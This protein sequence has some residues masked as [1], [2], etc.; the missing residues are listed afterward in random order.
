MFFGCSLF[1][2]SCPGVKRMHIKLWELCLEGKIASEPLCIRFGKWLRS[3]L[4]NMLDVYDFT[5]EFTVTF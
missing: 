2:A 5:Y 3:G 1:K 4:N